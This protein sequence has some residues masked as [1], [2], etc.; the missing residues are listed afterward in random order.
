ML[1]RGARGD[2]GE[3]HDVVWHVRKANRDG[4]D[5]HFIELLDGGFQLRP[6]GGQL[7]A[8]LLEEVL[9]DEQA[10]PER[11]DRDGVHRAVG[12]G[13]VRVLRQLELRIGRVDFADGHDLVQDRRGVG[14]LGEVEQHVR[15]VAGG[16]VVQDAGLPG[17]V[18]GGGSVFHMVAGLLLPGFEQRHV[19]GGS[20]VGAGE[21]G[22][23]LEG[24][25]LGQ[26]CGSDADQRQGQQDG[27]DLLHG[28][29][30]LLPR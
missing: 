14:G 27:Q 8:V 18:R 17:F 21:G 15:L 9:V 2:D 4:H 22:N 7:Q 5:A 13:D 10:F 3:L 11:A 30:S 24:H 23:G 16:E 26:G 19:V 6:V 25:A 20:G 28:L 29:S 1:L 12:L